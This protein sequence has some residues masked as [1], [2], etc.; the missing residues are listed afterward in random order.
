MNRRAREVLEEHASCT[1]NNAYGSVLTNLYQ[2]ATRGRKISTTMVA[3]LQRGRRDEMIMEEMI[4][5]KLQGGKVTA[6][7]ITIGQIRQNMRSAGNACLSFT[8]SIIDERTERIE[9][10]NVDQM[11]LSRPPAPLTFH[12]PFRNPVIVLLSSLQF[13]E[14]RCS[15]N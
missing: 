12:T 4:S 1:R 5:L 15:Q 8:L 6:Y 14:F 13:S 7:S 2:V 3:Q 9:K 10:I 11:R